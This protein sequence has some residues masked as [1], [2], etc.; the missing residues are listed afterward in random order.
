MP[1]IASSDMPRYTLPCKTKITPS[2][3]VFHHL[4]LSSLWYNI[5]AYL[6]VCECVCI[7]NY[8]YVVLIARPRHSRLGG[9]ERV[10]MAAQAQ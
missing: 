6:C 1:F 10:R 8:I 7:Y 4:W 3:Q 2:L 9:K 5:E